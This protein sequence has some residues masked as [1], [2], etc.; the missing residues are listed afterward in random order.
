MLF[1]LTVC[2]RY[3][4]DSGVKFVSLR[5]KRKVSKDFVW[6][7]LHFLVVTNFDWSSFLG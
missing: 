6:E 5:K 4:N 7:S 3:P 2:V 1:L